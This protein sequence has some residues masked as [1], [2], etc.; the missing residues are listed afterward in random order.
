MSVWEVLQTFYKILSYS[1]WKINST[2]GFVVVP[3][4]MFCKQLEKE[5]ECSKQKIYDG[6]S[7]K[8]FSFYCGQWNKIGNNPH[9][10]EVIFH[11]TS[12]C[13]RLGKVKNG[14]S[15]S[16]MC[17]CIWL[18]GALYN[19]DHIAAILSWFCSTFVVWWA[20]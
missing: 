12:H 4:A 8:Y 10:I 1:S 11:R 3:L 19:V 17:C 18:C 6:N 20:E 2:Y 13:S 15:T 16:K 14:V 7:G 5:E 9:R